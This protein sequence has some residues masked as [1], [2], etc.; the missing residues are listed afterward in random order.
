MNN[1][2]KISR[3]RMLFLMFLFVVL[4][5]TVLMIVKSKKHVQ[6]DS[7]IVATFVLNIGFSIFNIMMAVN[8]NPFSLNMMFWIFNLFFFGAAPLL[9]YLTDIYAWNLDPHNN[10][11]FFVNILILLWSV[12]YYVC[13]NLG[14][15]TRI[16]IFSS[17]CTR[18]NSQVRYEYYIRKNRLCIFLVA[19]M[20]I[21]IYNILFVG[22]ENLIFRDGSQSITN[23]ATLNLLL[24]HGFNNLLLFTAA[25]FVIYV[26][27]TKKMK[28]S[29]LIALMCLV[30]S[31]FP[32]GIPR[33]MAASFYAGLFIIIYDKTRRGRWF[34][35]VL[36]G[37]LILI[38]PAINIFRYSF[39]GADI[40]IIKLMKDAFQNAYLEGHF[41]AHQMIISIDRYIG[42]FGYEF[43]GQILGA[44]LFFVPRSIWPGKPVG[45]GHTVISGLDQ[46]D[47]T[48]VS[49]PLVGEFYIGFGMV[50]VIIGAMILSWIISKLDR[51]YWREE[52]ELSAIR[53]IY[54]FS[55]FMFFFM[56]RG[57]LMSSWA[58]TFAQIVVGYVIWKILVGKRK[59]TD[60]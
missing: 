5:A 49:A 54:P 6:A 52:N 3:N 31:C 17:K 43:F 53:V 33:N 24:T 15:N 56:L 12:V 45:T 2:L 58:Y 21:M 16:K 10:E 50:G 57:D 20:L 7:I 30:I 1:K 13:Q 41:D 47:F 55:M 28:L 26:K 14:A 38:F 8:R 19:S 37:G 48:N 36:L 32:T 46:F 4:L 42:K 40:S 60:R 27:K 35:L 22:F 11:V 59:V 9:Q 18:Q 25:F 51:K 44:L 29:L 39:D 23:N 34:S